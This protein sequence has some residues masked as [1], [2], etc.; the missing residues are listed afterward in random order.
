MH[1]TNE[2]RKVTYTEKTPAE[3]HMIR[4]NPR[5]RDT[6]LRLNAALKYLAEYKPPHAQVSM[7]ILPNGDLIKLDG[8][9]RDLAWHLE[10]IPIPALLH[11]TIYPAATMGEVLE[12][13]G[14]FDNAAASER[15][16]DIAQGALNYNGIQLQTP[17]LR[18]GRMG[19]AALRLFLQIGDHKNYYSGNPRDYHTMFAAIEYFSAEIIALDGIGVGP[20]MFPPGIQ[21]AAILTIQRDRVEALVFW[22]LYA[23]QRGTKNAESMDAVQALIESVMR[24]KSTRVTNTVQDLFSKGISA[25]QSF[26]AKN[27]YA[28]GGCGVRGLQKRSLTKYLER[29]SRLL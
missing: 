14:M 6:E 16:R 26:Q 9:T 17:M 19:S 22:R 7:A 29:Q 5:Q 21:M 23:E 15:G 2:A 20:M 13:Y 11:V 27:R 8:H 4:N 25:F 1:G 3:W 10:L 18:N 28:I 24:S 12:L